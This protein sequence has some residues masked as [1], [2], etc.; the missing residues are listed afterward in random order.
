MFNFSVKPVPTQKKDTNSNSLR[1]NIYSTIYRLISLHLRLIF[2]FILFLTLY[3]LFTKCK[4]S[5][6]LH[7]YIISTV[8]PR[9]SP[10]SV[11]D[12]SLLSF[13]FYTAT[14]PQSRARQE[15]QKPRITKPS[16]YFYP[17]RQAL[18]SVAVYKQNHRNEQKSASISVPPPI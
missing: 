14:E 15:A 4:I 10:W 9:R 5:L 11:S 7:L 3:N 16:S 18:C 1:H 6:F 17:F 13:Y 8:L 12:S 2:I